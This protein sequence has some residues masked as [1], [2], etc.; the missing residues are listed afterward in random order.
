[1]LLGIATISSCDED[2]A[3]PLVKDNGVAP[4]VVVLNS[5]AVRNFAGG[6]EI[7][8][9][10]PD[11]KDVLYVLGEYKRNDNAEVVN[12]KSSVFNN[13]LIVEGFAEEAEY[14]VNLYAVDQSGNKSD[15]TSVTINPGRPSYL[16]V[17][18]S[19]TAEPTFGGLNVS[20]ENPEGG[21]TIVE[22]YS[23]NETGSL[24]F[25]DLLRSESPF[26][27]GQI[28][29]LPA[30]ETDFVFIVKDGFGNQ[31]NRVE[32]TT[33]PLYIEVF[34]RAKIRGVLQPY[35]QTNAYTG[36]ELNKL[37]DGGIGNNGFHTVAISQSADPDPVLPYYQGHEVNGAAYRVPLFTLDL[38]GLNQVYRFTYWPRVNY[39]WRH[40]SPK[41]FDL[42]GSDKLNADG[43]LDGWTLLLD[44]AVVVKPSGNECDNGNNTEEDMAFA[45]AGISFDISPE[46][47]KVRYIRFAQREAQNCISTLL[48]ISE[49]QFSGD[50]R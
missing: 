14:E 10:L 39:E 7:T 48:H 6:S 22:L 1:M 35:D 36:W 4:G 30:E 15:P 11:D 31:C 9:N 5:N 38:G 43:S 28:L 46:M 24:I 23:V 40:G 50:N 25:Q 34:D 18:E 16:D 37:Y 19:I 12:V 13:S 42:W 32:F 8:Y 33:T 49:I 27:T 2:Q 45:N 17:C 3:G 47:P 29:G 21:L 41:V 20:W 44:Q 26:G